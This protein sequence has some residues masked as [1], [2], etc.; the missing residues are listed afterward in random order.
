VEFELDT[1]V[2]ISNW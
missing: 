1:M 2:T